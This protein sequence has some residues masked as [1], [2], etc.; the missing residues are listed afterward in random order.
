MFC[1]FPVSFQP[2]ASL[3]KPTISISIRVFNCPFDLPADAALLY[4]PHCCCPAVVFLFLCEN[5]SIPIYPTATNGPFALRIPLP[6]PHQVI[7]IN[8]K[9]DC[10]LSERKNIWSHTA[11]CCLAPYP[12]FPPSIL[13]VKMKKTFPTS[14][15]RMLPSAVA[16]RR[17]QILSQYVRGEA[18]TGG[19]LDSIWPQAAATFSHIPQRK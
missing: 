11:G 8:K 19:K 7:R 15:S 3:H 13:L 18:W 2:Y 5:K 9:I 1:F 17:H 16:W 12:W 10:V 14:F 6:V 4:S